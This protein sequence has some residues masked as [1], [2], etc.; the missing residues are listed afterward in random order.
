MRRAGKCS[1]ACRGRASR[2]GAGSAAGASPQTRRKKDA[3]AALHRG[4]T[5]AKVR[6]SH[7]GANTAIR[8]RRNRFS[9]PFGLDA[10]ALILLPSYLVH[11]G[12]IGAGALEGL[13]AVLA[14][15]DLVLLFI[16][17]RIIGSVP[18]P[19]RWF[20]WRCA[21]GLLV[22]IAGASMVA[23]VAGG[24]AGA[25]VGLGWRDGVFL[26]V[27]PVMAGGVNAG[28]LPL[29]MGMGMPSGRPA[30]WSP[31]CCRRDRHRSVFRGHVHLPGA[32]PRRPFVSPPREVLM[33]GFF[34]PNLVVVTAMVSARAAAGCLISRWLGRILPR[35]R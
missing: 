26:V 9:L 30:R 35:A 7:A 34:L 8:M 20:L 18:S 29:A 24:L 3:P 28:V 32:D 33:A 16:S 6:A 27:V 23:A 19:D 17:I 2:H 22:L 13:R 4:G 15:G 12:W 11:A 14:G 31:A 10:V 5:I 1:G 21:P 25:A